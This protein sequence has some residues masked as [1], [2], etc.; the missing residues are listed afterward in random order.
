MVR[1]ESIAF[2]QGKV[3]GLRKLVDQGE[4]QYLEFKRK[5]SYPEKIVRELIAFA[6]SSGGVLLI[7]VDDDRSIPGVKFPE[8]ES[9]VIH[10]ELKNHCRPGLAFHEEIIPISENRYVLK[11]HIPKSDKRPHFYVTNGDRM[12]FVRQNDQSIKASKEM[13]EILRR[14]K[15]KNGTKLVYG[16]AEQKIIH[17]L[18]SQTAISLEDFSKLTGLNRFMASRKL[19]RMVL[20][21][22]LKIKATDKGDLF[23][24][25]EN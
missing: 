23:S 4:G 9:I 20:A 11:W 22:V 14:N 15:S 18:G 21:N 13:C 25:A 2:D 1:S 5:A 24:R 7:G 6:N 8:E 12:S 10:T 3:N 19:V 17:F 16:E